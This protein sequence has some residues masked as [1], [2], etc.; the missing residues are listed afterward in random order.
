MKDLTIGEIFAF[1]YRLMYRDQAER[2]VVVT[3]VHGA[4]DFA[5]WRQGQESALE[6]SGHVRLLRRAMHRREHLDQIE[7]AP[8]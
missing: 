8:R 7:E 3:F 5:T 4:R 1:R 6:S 2:V